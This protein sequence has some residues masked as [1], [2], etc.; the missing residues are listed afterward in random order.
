MSVWIR[1]FDAFKQK[2]MDAIK[3]RLI[4]TLREMDDF[5]KSMLFLKKIFWPFSPLFLFSLKCQCPK[6]FETLHTYAVSWAV[7]MKQKYLVLVTTEV[8]VTR[9]KLPNVYKS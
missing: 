3:D 1:V 5:H 6:R 4:Q 8:S 7:L 9:K 2:Q